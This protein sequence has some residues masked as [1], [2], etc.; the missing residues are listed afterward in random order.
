MNERNER[1]MPEDHEIFQSICQEFGSA[2]VVGLFVTCFGEDLTGEALDKLGVSGVM[3]GAQLVK[4]Y[5]RNRNFEYTGE[6]S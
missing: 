6:Q 2:N 5:G 3:S 1:G 4:I